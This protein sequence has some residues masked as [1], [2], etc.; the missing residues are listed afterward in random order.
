MEVAAIAYWGLRHGKYKCPN[1]GLSPL[2]DGVGQVVWLPENWG[3]EI[4]ARLSLEGLTM[5]RHQLES[6]QADF[7]AIPALRNLTGL[8]SGSVYKDM[9][10]PR[11]M[12]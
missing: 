12:T 3:Q 7:R 8:G 1:C 4:L 9:R 5:L 6:V 2:L 10:R 11:L